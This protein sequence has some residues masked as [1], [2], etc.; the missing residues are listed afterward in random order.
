MR[1]NLPKS[2]FIKVRCNKCKNEQII[3]GCASTFINCL[4]CNKE[5]AFPTGGKAKIAAR[6]L[7]VLE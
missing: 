2:R 4:V 1:S 5:V 3:F 6:V 7:E